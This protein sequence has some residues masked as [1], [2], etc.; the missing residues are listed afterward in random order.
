[1]HSFAAVRRV[2]STHLCALTNGR[3]EP[4]PAVLMSVC[5]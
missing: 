3:G 1:M 5:A 4:D 2:R